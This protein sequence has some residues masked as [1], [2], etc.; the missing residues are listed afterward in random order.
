MPCL[1]KPR[2]AEPRHDSPCQAVPCLA[3]PNLAEPC[4]AEPRHTVPTVSQSANAVKVQPYQDHRGE[5]QQQK[6]TIYTYLVRT[7]LPQFIP[8]LQ[9]QFME[10]ALY[11]EIEQDER[12]FEYQEA[13]SRAADYSCGHETDET[14]CPDCIIE[15]MYQMRI[16]PVKEI[17][18]QLSVWR[19]A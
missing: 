16:R 6:R 11:S 10:T 13:K 7:V 3:T 19:E 2:L 8:S 4:H 9:N 18:G 5:R 1:A 12:F 14:P 15:S 17:M